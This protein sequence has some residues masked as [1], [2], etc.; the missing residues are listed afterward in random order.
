MDTRADLTAA[1]ERLAR[2]RT[3]VTAESGPPAHQL[4]QDLREALSDDLDAP[5]ALRAVDRWVEEQRLR[6]G[7]DPSAP[8]LVHDA[9]DAL[10]GIAL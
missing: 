3:A 5:R 2:W 6:G 7:S 8:A 10:L 9:V 1:T 4:L